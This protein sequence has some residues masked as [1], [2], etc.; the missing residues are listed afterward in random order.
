M[1]SWS[2]FGKP[3]EVENKKPSVFKEDVVPI[4]TLFLAILSLFTQNTPPWWVSLAI[5]IFVVI[6]FLFLVI[7][8]IAR[9][10]RKWKAYS[11]RVRLEKDCLPKISATL[12]VFKQLVEQHRADTIWGVWQ[13]ESKTIEMQKYIK[14]NH[15]HFSTLASWI[16]HLCKTIDT[17]EPSD[18]KSMA[19]E[20]SAWI[21]Q[22]V[23]FG[24]DAY[25]QFDALLKSNQLDAIR[26][27]EIKQSW[28]HARD[29][30][31][32]AIHN[33]KALCAEIKSSFDQDVCSTYYETLKTLE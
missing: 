17:A 32:Q 16:E 6:V 21:Q 9:N 18:F 3:K 13:N 29:E 27:R 7:P 2:L 15:S 1:D 10:W 8:A 4:G 11:M 31:N 23:S 12:R 25:S 30:H 19:A 24:R 28:N 26:G 20:T 22:Y 14:P 5:V 33:W